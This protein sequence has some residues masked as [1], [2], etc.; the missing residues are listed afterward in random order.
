MHI[1]IVR[2]AAAVAVTACALAA[3]Q[4]DAPLPIQS[5]EPAAETPA[6][7]VAP[8]PNPAPP[9]AAGASEAAALT[10]MFRIQDGAP[11]FRDCATGQTVPV[12]KSGP[13]SELEQVYL[14]SGIEAGAELGVSLEGRYL[15]GQTL[16]GKPSEIVLLVDKF[17]TLVEVA[18][19]ARART[20]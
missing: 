19:C 9:S 6:P 3:C 14:N 12:A 10:G 4:P 7:A 16:D 20:E 17:D 15:E 18:D 2:H 5:A 13:F 11:V 1:G 8:E